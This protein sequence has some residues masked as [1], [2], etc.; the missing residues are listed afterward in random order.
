MAAKSPPPSPQPA[1]LR[2]VRI[3]I[4]SPGDVAE[5][6]RLARAVVQALGKDPAFRDHLALDPVLWDDPE[7][8]A[9]MLATLT[10][11]ES[12][13]RGLTRP[14]DCEVVV[15]ILWSRM[16]T[17]L[18]TPLRADGSQ[19]L[20]GTEWEYVDARGGAATRGARIVVYRCTRDPQVSLRD[21]EFQEKKRQLDLVDEF[22]LRFEGPR[23]GMV[24]SYT[25]YESPQ[26]FAKR[27]ESDLRQLLPAFIEPQPSRSSARGRSGS[28]GAP[29]NSGRGV[30]STK[31]KLVVPDAYRDWIK[32]ETSSLELLGLGG[33]QGRSFF[34]SSVYVPLVTTA[35]RQHEKFDNRSAKEDA[36]DQGGSIA[37]LNLL[38]KDSLYVPGGPGSGKSTFCRWVAW[39]VAEG[40]MPSAELEAPDD[41]AEAFPELLR[42]KLPVLVPL[43]EFWAALPKKPAGSTL[44]ARELSDTLGR[45]LRD[46]AAGTGELSLA[47]FIE[48]GRTLVIFDGVDEV[49]TTDPGSSS[50]TNPRQ[51][52]LTGLD[53]AVTA[54][55]PAGNRLLVTS[56]PYGLTGDE[57]QKVGLSVAQ[58]SDLPDDLQALLVG[59]WFR[60][61][62]RD[63]DR[64]DASAD[65]LMSDI[66][67]RDWLQPLAANPLMLTAMCAIYG[68]GGKLPQDRHQLYDRIVDSVL[69]KRYADPKRR[70][71]VRFELCAIAHAM[72]TGEGLGVQ[73]SEPLP[74]ATFDEA[75]L[76]LRADQAA[77][78]QQESVLGPREA[79]EDL[80][81]RSGVLTDTGDRTLAFY[82]FSIQEFMAAE[83]IFELRLDQLQAVFDERGSVA[84]WRNTLSFLFGRYMGAFT[85]PT[86]PLRLLEALIGELDD[87]AFGPQT[88]AG[89][90]AEML[91]AKGFP[92]DDQPA[93]SL[94]ARLQRSMKG[95]TAASERCEAGTLLGKLGDPRFDAARW[96]LPAGDTLGFEKVNSGPFLMGT[97]E[98]RPAYDD[99][100][101]PQHEVDVPTFYIGRF[102]VTV[103][104]F[105]MYLAADASAPREPERF[106][107]VPNH[108]VVRVSWHEALGYCRWLTDRLRGWSDAPPAVA[109]WLDATIRAGWVV[110]LPSEAQWEKA[111]RGAV[112]AVYPWGDK[113]DPEKANTAIGIGRTSSVGAFPRGESPY[114]AHD[115]SGNVWEWTRSVYEPYPYRADDG[116]ETLEGDYHRVVRGGSFELPGDFARAAIRFIYLPVHRDD[117]QGF[118]VVVSRS[119]L[120]RLE[121][122]DSERA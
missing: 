49:P 47:G 113:F 48:A 3:F 80:L 46:R 14:S 40:S 110:T 55:T 79:R 68:D 30:T 13:N 58:I 54:W 83:R 73:H 104:Q 10:P 78:T 33:A 117:G 71:R 36:G 38:D 11:Q 109:Q 100:E 72:H 118:R 28:K 86:R 85:V 8:P 88:V 101:R 45:W 6:R 62:K 70:A 121:S 57:I 12:V 95:R 42:G 37:L 7:A 91:L 92:I 41:F 56:R 77:T 66:R 35:G 61:Q 115:M 65:H 112:G 52:L 93:R 60:I 27:L 96:A 50:E 20:S 116:R 2:R 5:E 16:G 84:N 25:S 114:H 24:G 120:D 89:D 107:G 90:C 23:G 122:G 102:P 119:H 59:R 108:P 18:E 99:D 29:K 67:D 76:A 105:Q 63:A 103:A 97:E 53:N 64:G 87:D 43:R 111:A 31:E 44:S 39:L 81:V 15:T 1:R 17:P 22:F 4:S 26:D 51:L 75:E 32:K 98:K 69:T 74:Q 82:H 21:P 94:G 9:A 19:Y 34:L 106:R